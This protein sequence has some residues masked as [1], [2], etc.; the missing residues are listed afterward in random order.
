MTALESTTPSRAIWPSAG[1]RA[2]LVPLIALLTLAF[3]ARIAV[4]VAFGQQYFWSNSYYFYYKIAEHLAAGEAP[5]APA[6]CAFATPLYPLFLTGSVLAGHSFWL[7]ILPQAL[8]GAGTALCAYLIGAEL[9]NRRTGMLACA[10][11]AFYPYY[12]MHDTALQ[13]TVLL[14]FLGALSVWLLLRARRLNRNLD[15]FLAGVVLGTLPL[16]RASIALAIAVGILWCFLWGASGSFS[17]K[18]RKSSLLAL[19]V[20]LMLGPW[21]F[22]TYRVTGIP[23]ISTE[24]G[25][26]LW[27]GNNPDTFSHYPAASIDRS[28]DEAMRN[29]SVTDTAQLAA[30]AKDERATSNWYMHRAL[31]FMRANPSAVLTGAVRKIEAGFSSRL[32]PHRERLAQAAYFVGYFPVAVLG[33]LG[34]AMARKQPGTI[35]VA[36]LFLTFIA[37][38]AIFWAH[39]SHRTYLDVYW[40]V[41]AASVLAG[42]RLRPRSR[43]KP[44]L[45]SAVES[46]GAGK[47]VFVRP[48]IQS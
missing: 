15:W 7:V 26:A 16:V 23:V 4:R 9:F 17:D 36:L 39:T 19:A 30:L 13:Y 11:T 43:A 38:T 24:T 40:I 35:L 14:T 21:L 33:L 44:P 10:I 47:S 2:T 31:A 20:I 18:L 32:N 46:A 6:G 8:L 37:V 48:V 34:M 5:C 3:A 29:L 27:V 42:I 28:R 12:V 1:G 41:F 25:L 45:S 22:Y